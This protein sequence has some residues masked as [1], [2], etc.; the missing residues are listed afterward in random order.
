MR[1][2]AF[3]LIELLVALVLLG[4]GLASFSRAA[5]AVARLDGDADRR[6]RLAEVLR[7]RLDTL[8]TTTCGG[9]LA[10][11][12]TADGMIG[13]WQATSDGRRWHLELQVAVAGRSSL[14][15][16]WTASVPCPP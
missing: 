16:Q 4:V 8:A 7:T 14:A 6:R 2:A 13:A 15:R 9:A 10:G 12:Y 1:R 11:A 5:A 3:S